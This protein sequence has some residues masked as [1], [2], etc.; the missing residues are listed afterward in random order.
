MPSTTKWK[1]GFVHL[2]CVFPEGQMHTGLSSFLFEILFWQ[3]VYRPARLKAAMDVSCALPFSRGLICNNDQAQM[4][5]SRQPCAIMPDVQLLQ[6]A[7]VAQTQGKLISRAPRKGI[8]IAAGQLLAATDA[9]TP[10]MD[11][12]MV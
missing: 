1:S 5:G 3:S 7:H 8:C 10:C 11:K 9:Q 2:P 6:L 4:P 12:Q